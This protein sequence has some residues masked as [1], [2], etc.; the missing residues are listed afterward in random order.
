MEKIKWKDI[1]SYAH[2]MTIEKFKSAVDRRFFIDYPH[3]TTVPPL[4]WKP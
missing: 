4:I 2:H 1:P 3:E